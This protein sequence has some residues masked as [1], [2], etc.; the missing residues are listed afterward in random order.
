MDSDNY[1]TRLRKSKKVTI[2]ELAETVGV[3]SACISRY[4]KGVRKMPVETA[5]KIAQVLGVDWWTLYN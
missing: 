5:K 1:L 2:K 4:G 3:S